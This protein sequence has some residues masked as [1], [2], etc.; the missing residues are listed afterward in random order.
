MNLRL[1]IIFK[2]FINLK[3]L[4][5]DTNLNLLIIIFIY[6]MLLFILFIVI[7]I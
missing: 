7:F 6:K 2:K 1:C 5:D 3:N 4:K